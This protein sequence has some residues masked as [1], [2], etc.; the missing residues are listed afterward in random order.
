MFVCMNTHKCAFR[1]ENIQYL[2]FKK[3]YLKGLG[4]KRD[5]K[6]EVSEFEERSI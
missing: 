5:N 3:K 6:E 2:K 4:V 1:T